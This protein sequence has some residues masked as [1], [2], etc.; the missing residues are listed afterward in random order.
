MQP[1]L[2]APADLQAFGLTIDSLH[3]VIVRPPTDTIKDTTVYFNPDSSQVRLAVSLELK[4][5][6][7]TL[8]VH[9]TLS[10]GGVPLFTGSTSV[11]V[12]VG[13]PPSGAAPVSVPL[14]FTGSGAGVTHLVVSPRDSVIREGDSLRFSVTADAGGVPVTSF[15]VAWQT[16]DSLRARV[17]AFGLVRAPLRRDTV[18]I[19]ARTLTGARDSTRV[20]FV[21]VATAFAIAGGNT[22]SAVVSTALAQPLRVRVTAGDGLGV[23]G[24][25]VQFQ[26]LGA[27]GS[28][29]GA[30]LVVT[31]DSGLAQTA[32]TLGPTAGAQTFQASVT[33]FAPLLFSETGTPGPISATHSGVTVSTA[34]LASA[35]AATVILLG[36]DAAGNNVTT[37]G[38]TVAFSASGG[39]ST[40]T[41][42]SVTDKGDGTY[43]ATFIG[44]LAGTATTIGATINGSTVTTALPQIAV[45]PGPPSPGASVLTVTSGLV[46]SG[47]SATLTLQARD[48]AGN[49]LTTGGA[50]VVFSD[51]GGTSVG[52]ISATVDHGNGLY[53]ATFTAVTAGTFTTIHATLN[54]APVAPPKPTITVV[55]GNAVTAQSIIT[56]SAPIVVSGASA[57]LT[58]QGRDAAGNNLTSG[59]LTVVFN[60]SGG[61]STGTIG[62]TTDN[63]NGTYTATFT[64]V[65]AG[66]AITI[67]ATI[68]GS[69]VTSTLPTIMVIAGPASV[70]TSLVTVSSGTVASGTA[71]TLTLQAKDAAGNN[72]PTGGLTVGFTRAGG[73]STGGI[74]PTT[75]NGNG[76]YTAIFTAV[77]AGTGTTIGATINGQAVTSTLPVISVLPGPASAATS[78]VTVS[79]TT[80]LSSGV[81]TLTLQAKDA[82]GNNLPTGGLTVVFTA[83]GGTSTGMIGA[84][85]DNSNGTYTG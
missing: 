14:L 54:G 52:T 2:A 48:A 47:A 24:V 23:K 76:T 7:E 26:A 28:A 30:T 1:L 74:G 70:A 82:A 81:V 44:V 21:P 18:T 53:T 16:S 17:N 57:T 20:T 49:K 84:T 13:V 25:S 39:T 4:A 27:G 11:P 62:A 10:A 69:P 19:I 41:L 15:Y 5:A 34:T 31:D 40:G 3:L 63:G 67:G 83:S 45:V 32:A 37:G 12:S 55:P 73:T 75:D 61:A 64:G 42:S 78:V 46:A 56:V 71:V 29:V 59:G 85:T 80:V 68:N 77:L 43:T 79:N 8:S 51:S 33:G 60:S 36:K 58:L 9:L 50:T 22:Q 66:G 35:S 72:L 6:V 38:A 65:V